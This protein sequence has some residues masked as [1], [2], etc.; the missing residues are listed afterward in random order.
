MNARWIS[1]EVIGQEP[2]FEGN[3]LM[4]AK[5]DYERDPVLSDRIRVKI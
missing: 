4:N 2:R 1:Y 5:D 3:G